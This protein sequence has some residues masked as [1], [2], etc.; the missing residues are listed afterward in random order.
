MNQRVLLKWV[1]LGLFLPIL[2]LSGCKEKEETLSA[3]AQLTKD[4]GIIEAY[5]TEKGLTATKT[6]SGLHFVVL[7]PG[8]NGAKPGPE[9]LVEV[10][11]RG[12]FTNGDI[13]D[14]TTGNQSISFKLN[15]VISGWTE[16]LQLMSKGQKNTLLL[17]S[18]LGYGN[19][20]PPGIPKN[21]VLIFDVKLVDF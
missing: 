4:I 10:L 13:F 15:Q 2:G 16:G 8:D 5:L 14:Q 12:Y 11:Y 21:A 17:P 18:A 9:T 1:L 19:N 7:E 6:A 3:E 20:P